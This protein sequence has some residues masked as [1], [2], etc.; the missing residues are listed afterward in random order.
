MHVYSI[1][2]IALLS[3][4]VIQLTRVI[5]AIRSENKATQDLLIS[6]LGQNDNLDPTHWSLWDQVNEIRVEVERLRNYIDKI[7]D[8]QLQQQPSE[9]P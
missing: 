1:V 4:V 5:S 6:M 2:L 8:A 3:L 9:S 7:E